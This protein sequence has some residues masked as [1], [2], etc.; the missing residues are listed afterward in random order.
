MEGSDPKQPFGP[1]SPGY[2][3]GGDDEPEER[4]PGPAAARRPS[5]A[6]RG[7]QSP[8]RAP[9]AG[10]ERLPAATSAPGS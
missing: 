2:G 7:P 4:R 3:P 8:R 6:R 5:V 1:G 9:V 10:A